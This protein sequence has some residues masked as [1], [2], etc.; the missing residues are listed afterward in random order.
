MVYSN[1]NLAFQHYEYSSRCKCLVSLLHLFLTKFP[2]WRST[3]AQIIKFDAPEEQLLYLSQ[4]FFA[5]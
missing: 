1:L 5:S 4:Y 2:R 3:D